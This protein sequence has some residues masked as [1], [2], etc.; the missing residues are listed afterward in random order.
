MIASIGMAVAHGHD[1]SYDMFFYYYSHPG[2]FSL[3][4]FLQ[5]CLRGEP[6]HPQERICRDSVRL[7]YDFP[8][9]ITQITYP[10][11][12][13]DR[14]LKTSLNWYKWVAGG[15][16]PRREAD[17]ETSKLSPADVQQI[18]AQLEEARELLLDR[19]A[20]SEA[21]EAQITKQIATWEDL[22]HKS[23]A[24]DVVQ[25]RINRM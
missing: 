6:L 21:E 11:E 16:L 19:I 20:H 25:H 1:V 5:S 10:P 2:Q 7:A 23:A 3:P 12:G 18:V 9:W 14:L 4:P 15:A 17:I 8:W 24:L 22:V 13:I